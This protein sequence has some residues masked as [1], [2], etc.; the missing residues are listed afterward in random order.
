MK[1]EFESVRY[2]HIEHQGFTLVELLVVI[3]IISILAGMLLPALENALDA[4]RTAKCSGSLKQIGIAS[5]FY[6]DENNNYYY[7]LY[8][9]MPTQT[10]AGSIIWTGFVACQTG[11]DGKDRNDSQDKLFDCPVKINSDLGPALTYASTADNWANQS[12]GYNY[13]YFDASISGV[14]SQTSMSRPSATFYIADSEAGLY[15]KNGLASDHPISSR[16]NDGANL[17]FVDGHVERKQYDD[18]QGINHLWDPFY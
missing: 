9:T 17:L 11:W 13:L 3:A 12:F 18:V 6:V 14:K 4:V 7:P 1:S 5:Q 8:D 10:S 15:I 2:K 16:H